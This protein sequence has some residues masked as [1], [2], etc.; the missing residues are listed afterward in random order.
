M[1]SARI[2]HR[3]TSFHRRALLS[4]LLSLGTMS[5]ALAKDYVALLGT[6]TGADSR[7]IYSVRLNSETGALSTP[8]LAAEISNPEFLA[9]HPNGR[10]VY[11]LTQVDAV[12]G[13]GKGAVAALSLDPK[14]TRLTL[15]NVESTDR[16]SLT[17]L[18]VDATG[19][20]VVAAAYGG[21][22]VAS[23]PL[24]NDGRVGPV[25][26]LISHN[27][28]VGPNQPRQDKPHPH[29]VTLSP[30]NRIAFVADLGVDR[31]YAYQLAHATGTVAAFNPPYFTIS[32]GSGPRHTAFSPDGKSFYVLDEL[33]STVTSCRYDGAQ[34]R[35]TP[36]ER[37]AALP[38]DFKG[39]S[40]ASEI[41][42]HPNGRFVY[43]ANRGHNSL[44][45]FSRNPETGALTRV[46]VVPTGGDT[47]RNFALTP[48][49][50]WLLCAHQASNNLT[51]FKVSPATGKLTSTPHTAT[52]PKAVCVLFLR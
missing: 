17:H 26:T 43:S 38:E 3:L 37:V 7:G 42:V 44:A 6:Y 50:A 48:D 46:E 41:R 34:G 32:A 47:P 5:A 20:M 21:A 39:K 16:T 9:L 49:G 51:V 22:Y 8:E 4:A 30:D 18:A 45:V 28:Q 13:K 33:D 1:F 11:A 15:L 31:V 52:V 27:D 24:K 23:F 35:A 36:F 12:S 25:A 40:T 2:R 10:I 19:H 29:S 14:T